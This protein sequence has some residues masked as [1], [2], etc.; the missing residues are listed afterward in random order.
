MDVGFLGLGAMGRAVAANLLK[1]GHRVRVWNRSPGAAAEL[2]RAG[3]EAA[4]EPALAFAGVVFS[5][6]ADDQALRET[7][8]DRGLLERAPAGTV[9]VNLA[10]ISVAL[11]ERLTREHERHGVEYVAAPVFGRPDAAAAGQL[12]IVAAGAAASL[13][14]VQPLLDVVGRRTWR[15][16]TEPAQ[17]NAVKIAGN[18]LIAAAI[19]SMAEAAVL[20]ERH[21]V[22]PAALLD[23]MTST[24][25]SAPVYKNY[26]AQ[27]VE[28]RWEPAGFRLVLGLK[29]VRLALEAGESS[30]SPMPFAGVLRDHFLEAI[31]HGDGERDWA[32][33]ADVARRHAGLPNPPSRD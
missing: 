26:G 29:D 6:L 30:R 28:R 22:P 5:M 27:I 17:A 12:A 31:A 9:H 1:A 24:L 14:R 15:V 11:A 10:T 19:E 21:G 3:A 23:V 4:A 18:F 20:V 32:A 13:D 2:A 25:F 8:L 16:G 7:V 33:V